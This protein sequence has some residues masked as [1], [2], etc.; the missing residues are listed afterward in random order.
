M[1]GFVSIFQNLFKGVAPKDIA[2]PVG[3]FAV[4]TEASKIGFLALINFVGVLSVNLAVLNIIPFPALDGGRLLF[5]LIESVI[6]KKILPKVEATAHS[7][8][9]I[10]L[11]LL[12]LAVTANDIQRLIAAGGITGFIDSIGK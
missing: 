9:M 6:G 8:G 12:I 5:I 10:I 1:M 2:G 11:L 3:I 7:I 4:T